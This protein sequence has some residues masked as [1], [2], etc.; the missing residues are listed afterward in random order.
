MEMVASQDRSR[1]GHEFEGNLLL[2]VFLVIIGTNIFIG[3]ITS[4]V[5]PGSSLFSTVVAIY[6]VAGLVLVIL[7]V[8][9]YFRG[10][11]RFYLELNR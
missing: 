5:H 8:V 4:H 11:R 3:S 2:A 6:F 7:G 1:I 10:R 9:V